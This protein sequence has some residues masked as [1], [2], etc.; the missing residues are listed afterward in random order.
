M[1][2]AYSGLGVTVSFVVADGMV[3]EERIEL[4]TDPV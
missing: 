4:P 2:D 3:G 1:S